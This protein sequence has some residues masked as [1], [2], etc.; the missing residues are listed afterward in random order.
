MKL[1]LVEDN[2]EQA[3]FIEQG[4][5]SAG[6]LLEH[7]ENGKAGLLMALNQDYDVIISDR[8]MPEMD[9]LSMLKALRAAGI[10]TPVLLLSALDSVSERVAGLTAGSDDYL[11][12]PFAF[13]ELLARVEILAK[14]P[15]QDATNQQNDQL[16]I[17][18]LKIDLGAQKA[19]RG[20]QALELSQREFR[21]LTYLAQN[22][23]RV[24]SRTMLIEAVWGLNFDPQ[25]NVIDVHVSRLR[26]KVD[27][28]G[29]K[30]LIQTVRG[31]G[32][33][34]ALKNSS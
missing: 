14:R 12:K 31:A 7:A 25:T 5:R 26:K 20:T 13:A 27:L 15:K 23:G 19:W 2:T 10:H 30:A 1:L 9:G 16:Q 11:I 22:A 24:I 3:R 32:Y 8:M 29:E 28:N 4:M 33:S 17:D 21:L 18:N 34:I 6:H